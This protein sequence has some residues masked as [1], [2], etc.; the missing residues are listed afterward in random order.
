LAHEAFVAEIIKTRRVDEKQQEPQ[1]I[2]VR[3]FESASGAALIAAVVGGILVQ[4]IAFSIQRGAREREFQQAWMKDVVRS[5]YDLV[6]RSLGASDDLMLLTTG[7][8]EAADYQGQDRELITKQRFMIKREFNLADSDWRKQSE[9][10]ALLI[11]FYYRDNPKP[12]MDAWDSQAKAVTAYMDCARTFHLRNRK[13]ELTKREDPTKACL[14]EKKE[15]TQQR[16]LL[17]SALSQSRP[18]LW[19]W[20][21]IWKH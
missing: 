4:L 8:F 18:S 2:L 6:G 10:L 11:G 3:F 14:N 13:L 5:A 17:T 1:S 7:E 9:S 15:V 20:W 21:Q 19:N 12:V 16:E